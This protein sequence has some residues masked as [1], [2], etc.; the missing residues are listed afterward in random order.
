ML[1]TSCFI[2]LVRSNTLSILKS[3]EYLKLVYYVD[4]NNL[5]FT[6]NTCNDFELINVFSPQDILLIRGYLYC[7]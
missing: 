5:Q 1:W 4:I 7:V 2:D 6:A 3:S